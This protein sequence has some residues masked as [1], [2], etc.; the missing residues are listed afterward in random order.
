MGLAGKAGRGRQG[1]ASPARQKP[2]R[3]IKGW[4]WQARQ[5]R[6]AGAARLLSN[7]AMQVWARQARQA[8]AGKAVTKQRN[9]RVGPAGKAGRIRQG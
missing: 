5:A 7:S 9:D 2:N 3:V 8:E 1:Q 4:A 6:P